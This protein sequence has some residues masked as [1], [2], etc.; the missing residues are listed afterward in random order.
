MPDPSRTSTARRQTGGGN[1]PSSGGQ[2]KKN[3]FNLAAGKFQPQHGPSSAKKSSTKVSDT[4]FSQLEERFQGLEHGQ[5]DLRSTVEDLN[6]LYNRLCKSVEILKRGGW[7]ITVGPFK[8][9]HAGL[10]K[11]EL[12]YLLGNSKHQHHTD[13]SQNDG[14]NGSNDVKPGSS[15]YVPPHQRKDSGTSTGSIPPHLR[16]K[17]APNGGIVSVPPRQRIGNASATA[18]VPPNQRN[19]SASTTASVPP[20]QRSGN[21]SNTTSVPP[22]QRNSSVSATKSVPPHLRHGAISQP[23]PKPTDKEISEANNPLTVDGKVEVEIDVS[24]IKSALPEA[25]RPS[26]PLTTPAPQTSE[27]TTHLDESTFTLPPASASKYNPEL[28]KTWMPTFITSLPPL[29][30][31]Q[32]L[33]IPPPTSMQTFHPDFLRNHLGGI[34]WSPGQIYIPPCPS[35]CMLPNRTYY[36][37]TPAHEPFLPRS[38]GT[39]GAKLT[40]FF[41]RNPEDAF[42]EH[43]DEAPTYADV[44]LFVE[45]R[46]AKGRV[47]CT[48]FGHYSQ[49]RWSDKLDYDR[50]GAVVSEGVRQYWAKELTGVGRPEW[51]TDK[52]MRHFFPMPEYE[53]R[54]FG[55]DVEKE[56]DED[57]DED[58]DEGMDEEEVKNREEGV[59][60]EY[61][62][63]LKRLRKWEKDARMKTKFIKKEF[64]LAAFER[65]D[66]DDPPALRLWWEYLECTSWNES[67][68]NMLAEYQSRQSHY[69]K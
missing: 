27:E 25:T 64:I 35:P 52:L 31:P 59:A 8:E 61:R 28:A 9:H 36:L 18:S 62:A 1:S 16:A 47:R 56:F 4:S 6:A 13:E 17:P 50:M 19:G 12:D 10:T 29:P 41:N 55:Y 20:H 68:Y 53:G 51:V 24:D 14:L 21:A 34:T 23:T 22:H 46:D 15:S 66:A 44:P 40:P 58:E 57:E 5:A 7:D 32:L 42:A 43:P 30:S 65:A 49:T 26:D 54:L 37:L 2:S 63:Y 38:P 60:K 33:A 48:Y 3:Q 69:S 39:H 67:F 11:A 45:G